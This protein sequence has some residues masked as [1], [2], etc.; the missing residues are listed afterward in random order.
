MLTFKFRLHYNFVIMK[1][2]KGCALVFLSLI[3][4]LLLCIFGIAFTVN[5]VALNPH[6]IEK[7]LNDITTET[8]KILIANEI[9]V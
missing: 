2:L 4:F 5:Q 3:L 8:D 9:V 1:V 7:I 6:T